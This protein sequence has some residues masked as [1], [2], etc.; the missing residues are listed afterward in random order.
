MSL[1]KGGKNCIKSEQKQLYVLIEKYN[2]NKYDF[3]K[4]LKYHFEK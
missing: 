2:F 3:L 1:L 4:F